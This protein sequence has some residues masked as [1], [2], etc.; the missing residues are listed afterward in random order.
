M[1]GRA[2]VPAEQQERLNAAV[3]KVM[4]SAR[5]EEFL[6]QRG[7]IASTL[8]LPQFRSFFAREVD[9]WAEVIQKADIKAP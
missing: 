6:R 8:T 5:M 4:A 3:R 1:F 2:D 9:L 7:A